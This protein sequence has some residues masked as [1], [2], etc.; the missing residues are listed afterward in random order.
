M[1][2]EKE[3]KE[4]VVEEKEVDTCDI[5][6]LPETELDDGIT[7]DKYAKDPEIDEEYAVFIN[8]LGREYAFTTDDEYFSKGTR[9]YRHGSAGSINLLDHSRIPDWLIR[10]ANIEPEDEVEIL[11]IQNDS[12]LE[13]EFSIECCTRCI[14]ILFPSA[15]VSEEYETQSGNKSI[16]DK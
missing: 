9:F 3:V 13:S 11:S 12:T 4:T 10:E 6:S 14:S 1:I 7:I 8:H 5:C 2:I 15:E 16:Y